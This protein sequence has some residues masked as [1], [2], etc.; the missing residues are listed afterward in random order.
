VEDGVLVI[1][2]GDLALQLAGL[3]DVEQAGGRGSGGC[4]LVHAG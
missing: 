4:V 3:E 1:E 2:V